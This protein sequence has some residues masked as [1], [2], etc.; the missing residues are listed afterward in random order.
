MLDEALHARVVGQGRCEL[1]LLHGMF[2]SGLYWGAAYDGLSGPGG[3]VAP[4][5]LGFGRSPRPNDGY[6]PDAH[7]DAVAETLR[8][9]GVD[10]PVVVG[11][12]SVGVLVALRVAIRHPDLVSEIV[13]F[14]PPIYPDPDT[15]RHHIA[16]TDALAGLLVVNQ[17]LAKSLCDLMCRYRRQAG[18]IVRLFRPSLPVPLALDRVKHSWPAYHETLTKLV[19]AAE[20]PGWLADVRVPVRLVAG[21]RDGAIDVAHLRAL[22]DAHPHIT[23]RVVPGAGHDL[24]LTHPDLCLA[25]LRGAL[26]NRVAAEARGKEPNGRPAT[27][28]HERTEPDGAR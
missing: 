13:R 8:A 28:D 22:T 11:A 16:R 26:E 1:V 17:R 12:H 27:A 21:A 19:L 20:A 6:T 4:D 2:N 24:P 15:A 10:Q 9:V 3:V 14:A 7:A 23:L 5:L 18:W 25:E